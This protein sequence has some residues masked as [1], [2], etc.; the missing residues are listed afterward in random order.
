[1]GREQFDHGQGTLCLC[2][3]DG[4]HQQCDKT[5]K[6]RSDIRHGAPKLVAQKLH[7]GFAPQFPIN[8]LRAIVTSPA[9]V[10]IVTLAKSGDA[11]GRI[12]CDLRLFGLLGTPKFSNGSLR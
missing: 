1:L 2:L 9:K 8:H 3:P 6:C 4:Q 11:Y 10:S 12:C 5:Q 7:S